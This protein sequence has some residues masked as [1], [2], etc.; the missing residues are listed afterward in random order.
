MMNNKRAVGYTMVVVGVGFLAF[1]AVDYVL[2]RNET[3]AGL[4]VA[5]IALAVVGAGL[6]RRARTE[7]A[8]SKK[9]GDE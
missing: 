6:V 3:S 2:K 5:G 8:A 1:N 9:A 4:A 7:E